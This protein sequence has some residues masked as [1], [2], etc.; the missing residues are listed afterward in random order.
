[1]FQNTLI[2]PLN[3]NTVLPGV[4]FEYISA[5]EI[6]TKQLLNACGKLPTR[7]KLTLR[8]KDG[9]D[10]SGQHAI[11]QQQGNEATSNIMTYMFT[12]L[13]LED[14]E[15]N[16]V[17]YKE[18]YSSSPFAA[19]PLFLLLGKETLENLADIEI[20]MKERRDASF[21]FMMGDRV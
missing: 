2:P 1:M 17:L 11:Y 18:P 9:V 15:T 8:I 19:R 20:A 6:T 4:G 16:E 10:G 5:L 21:K 3:R 13:T 14:G 7:N 12:P